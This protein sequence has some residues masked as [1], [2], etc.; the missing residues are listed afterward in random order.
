VL[1]AEKAA[2]AKADIS[3]VQEELDELLDGFRINLDRKSGAYRHLGM[4]VLRRDVEA[5]QAIERRNRGE[6][7]ET[8]RTAEPTLQVAQGGTLT[9]ALEGWKKAK[10]RGPMITAEFDNAVRRFM[11][12]HGEDAL[13]AAGESEDI[14]DALTGRSGGGVGRSYGAKEM[15]QRFGLARLA[16]A[17]AKV[18]YP[19]LDLSHL[20]GRGPS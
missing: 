6:A 19:G 10:Q 1:P 17:V 2:L 15:M 3:F 5:L 13:R 9:A 18:A 8:P 12:L 7:V 4:A 20:P 14:N 16:D 11:E